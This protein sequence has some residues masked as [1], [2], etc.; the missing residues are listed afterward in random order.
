MKLETKHLNSLAAAAGQC[1]NTAIESYAQIALSGRRH[2]GI[3]PGE[4]LGYCQD[5]VDAGRYVWTSHAGFLG[6]EGGVRS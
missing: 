3:L 4:E 1:G 5:A 2:N 6:G